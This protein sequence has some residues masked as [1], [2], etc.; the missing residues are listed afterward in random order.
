VMADMVL[1]VR[2]IRPITRSY[3]VHLPY[4]SPPDS[5]L[6]FRSGMLI[7]ALVQIVQGSHA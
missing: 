4:Q 5:H 6:S 2:Y 7:N 1:S 3:P